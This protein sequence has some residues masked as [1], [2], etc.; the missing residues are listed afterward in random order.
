MHVVGVPATKQQQT[1]AHHAQDLQQDP[2]PT[3]PVISPR[4]SVCTLSS[5]NNIILL[6]EFFHINTVF[7]TISQSLS[8]SIANV[9]TSETIHVCMLNRNQ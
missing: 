7:E 8:P 4:I 9:V 5:H 6:L 3:T 2:E 1:Y